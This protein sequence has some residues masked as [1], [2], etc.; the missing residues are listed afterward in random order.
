MIKEDL[1][2]N[3]NKDAIY[4]IVRFWLPV[5]VWAT[6]IFLFSN[7]TTIKTVDFFLGDF[8]LKKTAHIVEYGI[9]ATLLYRAFVNYGMD[10]KRAM[11]LSVLTAF[12]YGT[13]DEFHQSFI[14]GRTATVRDVLIDT[15]G[16][17]VAVYGIIRN[18]KKMPFV[19]RFAYKKLEIVDTL[20]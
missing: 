10:K 19:I 4:K 8:L 15:S 2:I 14:Y 16:A 7:R 13:S 5:V 6:I 12:L 9:F 1:I 18:I 20:L 11:L 3:K 17:F